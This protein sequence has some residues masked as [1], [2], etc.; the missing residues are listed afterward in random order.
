MFWSDETFA[1]LWGSFPEYFFTMVTEHS[2][3]AIWS[4][5]SAPEWG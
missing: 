1:L 2:S 3:R 4:W 5:D